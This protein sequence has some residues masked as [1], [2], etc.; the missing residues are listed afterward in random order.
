MDWIT[1]PAF[2]KPFILVLI[3]KTEGSLAVFG[4]D[5]VDF[6]SFPVCKQR[7][8]VLDEGFYGVGQLKSRENRLSSC[9][10]CGTTEHYR[11]QLRQT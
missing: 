7:E 3:L 10:T 11:Q 9:I 4:L 5:Y 2:T 6:V 8:T 1:G